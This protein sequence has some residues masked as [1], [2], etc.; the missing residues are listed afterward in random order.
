M[1]GL[2]GASPGGLANGTDG[3]AGTLSPSRFL[4]DDEWNHWTDGLDWGALAPGC[5]DIEFLHR[6]I[7][8][9]ENKSSMNINP[10]DPKIL[11]LS[12]FVTT[13]LFAICSWFTRAT[14][15][16]ML[17]GLIGGLPLIP[18]VMFYD[19]MAARFG[20]WHYPAV[21]SGSAPIAW[22]ISTA[23]FYGTALGLV[24][25]R[26]IRRFDR[27]GLIIFL[28]VFGLFGVSRDVAYSL[29]SNFIKFGPGWLPYPADFFAYVSGAAIVQL[30]MRWIAGKPG[31]DL[32]SRTRKTQ[33]DVT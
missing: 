2:S 20:L 7:F 33:Q 17:G 15:R 10:L 21:T 25:W 19:A 31:S 30:L 11:A 16:R 24:G 22:Y 12:L 14:F 28:I 6:L 3:L 27:W 8:Y 4:L 1:A 9:K 13:I 29:T 23:L 26:V 18:L 5:L 32:L